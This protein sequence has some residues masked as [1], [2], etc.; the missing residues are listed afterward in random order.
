MNLDRPV[1]AGLL[2]A[3]ASSE[4][5][6]MGIRSFVALPLEKGGTI[7]SGTWMPCGSRAWM[8]RRTGPA[9]TLPGSTG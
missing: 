7:M 8:M 5:S 6:A 1:V 9:M 2:L 3:L 4:T